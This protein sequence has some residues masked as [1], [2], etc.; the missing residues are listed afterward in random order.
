MNTG[1]H[2]WKQRISLGRVRKG[3][4]EVTSEWHFA[5]GQTEKAGE[6]E[7]RNR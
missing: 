5:D 1:S 3:F 2:K 6:A 7:Q 4:T